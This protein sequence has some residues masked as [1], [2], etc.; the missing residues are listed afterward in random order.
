M[1]SQ[2]LDF[3]LGEIKQELLYEFECSEE[4]SNFIVEGISIAIKRVEEK[5]K[6]KLVV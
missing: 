1:D 4:S 2:E 6:N 5:L 3:L